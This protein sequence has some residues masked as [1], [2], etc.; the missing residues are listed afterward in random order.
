MVWSLQPL[1]LRPEPRP[2]GGPPSGRGVSWGQLTSGPGLWG[3]SESLCPDEASAPC[4]WE[5]DHR[6]PP[7]HRVEAC[8]YVG[9][10]DLPGNRQ[11]SLKAT[12]L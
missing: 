12:S 8:S 6:P 2:P 11:I 5:Q 1:V 4:S 3:S 9:W 7:V 10:R